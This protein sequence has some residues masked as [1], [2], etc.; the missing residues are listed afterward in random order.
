M[1]VDTPHP[2]THA[3]PVR[4]PGRAAPTHLRRKCV[5]TG[6]LFRS[7]TALAAYV[8][9]TKRVQFRAAEPVEEY[10]AARTGSDR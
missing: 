4:P 6:R 9:A 1:N 7:P 5:A 2:P 3:S 10:Y 8:I